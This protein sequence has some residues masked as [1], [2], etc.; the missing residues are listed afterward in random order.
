MANSLRSPLDMMRLMPVYFCESSYSSYMDSQTMTW[1]KDRVGKGTYDGDNVSM[2][3]L[4][5]VTLLFPLH[6]CCG[7]RTVSDE[8]NK[9]GSM[10]LREGKT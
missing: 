3:I 8:W 2:F 10:E 1:E 6:D 7:V 5:G 9:Q 4:A